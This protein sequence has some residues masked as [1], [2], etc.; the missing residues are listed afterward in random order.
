MEN[1]KCPECGSEEIGEIFSVPYNG[2]FYC[3]KTLMQCRDC[4]TCWSEFT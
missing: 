4:K 1:R 2:A 3:E